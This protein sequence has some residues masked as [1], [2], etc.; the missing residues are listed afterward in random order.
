MITIEDVAKRAGVSRMTV[1]RVINKKGYVSAE[2]RAR[3]EA[4]VKELNYKPNILAKAL[5]TKRTS[6]LAYVMI[7]ISDPF[8]NLVKQ[9]F[10]SI[11]Y[12]GR[13]TSM[14]CDV[15]SAERQRDYFNM[16]QEICIGGAVFHHLAVTG[17]QIG[18]LEAAG[19]QCVLLD[20]EYDLPG[21]SCINTD[22]YAGGRM[23]AEHLYERGHRRIGCIHGVLSP[24]QSGAHT[25]YKDS[26]QFRIWQQRTAGFADA[27]RE[28]GLD[29]A[30]Y[31]LCNG[32]LDIAEELSH[33]IVDKILSEKEPITA[34]Y[35]EDD[36]MA[37][38]VYK[39]LQER[40]VKVPE[41]IAIIGHDGLDMIKAVHPQI[42]TIEQPRYEMG[43]LAAEILIEQIEKGEPPRNV[44]LKPRLL[45]GE[46]T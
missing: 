28:R 26:F 13:Y 32:D 4:A 10:E 38:T 22:N 15:H 16:F 24:E 18:E 35:C 5:V 33:G 20:N 46:T 1:S 8:H 9:G 25:R 37:L 6:I 34:V 23:A 41:D 12:H 40:G 19:I 30:G 31:F 45:V 11:A 39:R 29:A 2:A 44:V 3:V 21:V 43:R 42:T 27:L 17:E 14:M 7:D 36:V